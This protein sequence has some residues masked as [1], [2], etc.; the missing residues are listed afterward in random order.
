MAKKARH[1]PVDRLGVSKRN[2]SPKPVAQHLKG[3]DGG[4]VVKEKATK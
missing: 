3:L 2:I 1:Y 4:R